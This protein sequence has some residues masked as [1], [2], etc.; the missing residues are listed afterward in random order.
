MALIHV[1]PAES[2][3]SARPRPDDEI[4]DLTDRRRVLLHVVLGVDLDP[5]SV[6]AVFEPDRN[7]STSARPQP[8]IAVEGGHFAVEDDPSPTA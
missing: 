8:S 3:I 1:P 4:I 6:D 7:R 5:A 2:P